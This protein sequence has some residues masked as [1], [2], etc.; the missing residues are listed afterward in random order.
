MSSKYF[1][2]IAINDVQKKKQQFCYAE[3]E[4]TMFIYL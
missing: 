4:P 1:M 2:Y 3:A